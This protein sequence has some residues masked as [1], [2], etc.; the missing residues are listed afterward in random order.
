MAAYKKTGFLSLYNS[1]TTQRLSLGNLTFT[2]L[3]LDVTPPSV[4]MRLT[5]I[6]KTNQVTTEYGWL[7][8]FVQSLGLLKNKSS[9]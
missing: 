6:F 5:L 9:D 2:R 1:I 8:T 3:L 7:W 4:V